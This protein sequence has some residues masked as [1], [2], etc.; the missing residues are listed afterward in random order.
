MTKNENINY[1]RLKLISTIKYRGYTNKDQA[2]RVTILLN[3]HDTQ[4]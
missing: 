4:P 2:Q 1:T 3:T